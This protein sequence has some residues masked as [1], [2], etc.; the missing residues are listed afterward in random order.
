MVSLAKCAAEMISFIYDR[1]ISDERIRS[2]RGQP[3]AALGWENTPAAM[4]AAAPSPEFAKA[5]NREPFD[6]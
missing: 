5:R 2:I 3:A 1:W 4:S 6:D